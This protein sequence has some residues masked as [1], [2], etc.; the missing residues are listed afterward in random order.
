[1][2]GAALGIFSE[3]VPVYLIAALASASLA[4]TGLIPASIF[5]AAPRFAQSSALL[6]IVL[7]LINQASN[8]GS[9][10]GPAAIASVVQRLGWAYAPMLFFCVTV[11]GVTIALLLR[12]AM[13]RARYEP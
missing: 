11:S 4:V 13:N 1:M 3:N 8:L 6:A 10:F 7:G 12:R 2:G 5:A 9:L